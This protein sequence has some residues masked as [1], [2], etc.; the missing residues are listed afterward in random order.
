MGDHVND[1]VCNVVA[2]SS[3]LALVGP[4]L[5]LVLSPFLI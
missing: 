4:S 2:W 5:T 1:R 3:S